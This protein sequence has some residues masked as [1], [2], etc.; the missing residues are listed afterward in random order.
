MSTPT[1][2]GSTVQRLPVKIAISPGQPLARLLRD[3]Y[4]VET[5]IATHLD[6]VVAAARADRSTALST[7]RGQAPPA[8]VPPFD[9]G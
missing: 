4:S 3:G 9:A 8:G 1:T 7:P 2:F 5:V 6:D